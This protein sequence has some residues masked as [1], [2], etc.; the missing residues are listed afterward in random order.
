MKHYLFAAASVVSSFLLANPSGMVVVSGEARIGFQDALTIEVVT[1]RNTVLEWDSFSIDAHETARFVMPDVTSHVLSRVIGGNVS[2]ILGKLEANGELYLINS[3]GVLVGDGAV[4]NTASFIASTFDVLEQRET[5]PI[6]NLGTITASHVELN[7]TEVTHSGKINAFTVE[8]REGRSILVAG[9]AHL[10]GDLVTIGEN[11]EINA[12]GDFGG[13][14][15]LIGGDFQGKNPEIRNAVFV[16]TD[17]TANIHADALVHGDGGKVVLWADN[18]N[19]FYGNITAK[20][21]S[22]SGN[23]G[24]VEVSGLGLLAYHGLASTLAPNGNVGTLLLD[25]PTLTISTAPSTNIHFGGI[26]G[27]NTYCQNQIAM[28]SN[29]N[30]KQLSDQLSH[31]AVTVQS[32]NDIVIKANI[33]GNHPLFI[34]S[35]SNVVIEGGNGS[36][37]KDYVVIQTPQFSI[38]AGQTLTIQGGSADNTFVSIDGK[39]SVVIQA[40]A[41]DILGGTGTGK[42]NFVS[43]LSSQGNFLMT[44][45]N[46]I[47]FQA[48]STTTQNGGVGIG[49]NKAG[50]VTIVS[51]LGSIMISAGSMGS[52]N[53]VLIESGS[54]LSLIAQNGDI[55][56][57]GTSSNNVSVG[58]SGN[59]I[60]ETETLS[61]TGA[62]GTTSSASIVCGAGAIITATTGIELNNTASIVQQSST[63]PILMSTG[64]GL[65]LKNGS[66]VSTTSSGNT[67]LNVDTLSLTNGARIVQGGSGSLFVNVMSD[68][69][70]EGNVTSPTGLDALNQLEVHVM[71]ALTLSS[72][73]GSVFLYSG[74]ELTLT[75]ASLHMNGNTSLNSVGALSVMSSGI[76]RLQGMDISALEATIISMNGPLTIFGSEIAMSNSAQVSIKQ[77]TETLN[78]SCNTATLRIF[79]NA[80]VSHHGTG[81]VVMNSPMGLLLSADT[82]GGASIESGGPFSGNFTG[83]LLIQS[84][85]SNPATI[86]AGQDLVL[87]TTGS[88]TMKTKGNN[89]KG[90]AELISTGGNVDVFLGVNMAMN[91]LSTVQ[92][93]NVLIVIDNNYPTSPAVGPGAFTYSQDA[94]IKGTGYVRI[95]TA[96]PSQNNI[97]KMSVINGIPFPGASANS[98]Y[99]TYYPTV[100]PPPQDGS[101]GFTI[102]YKT[103]PPPAPI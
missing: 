67:T 98:A 57:N 23:G 86:K 39:N 9:T 97:H 72:T 88:L 35:L 54:S 44:A 53:G 80:L 4:I 24:F 76:V 101:V 2:E 95:Y 82:G 85:Q 7:G 34:N 46:D 90:L 8:T 43:L 5:G 70:V 69:T 89:T 41:I 26:C 63:A 42:N 49:N 73:L 66:V 12:S 20:G 75:A 15:I 79:N 14:T 52:V 22:E 62:G 48:S 32:P 19:A 37:S 92:G 81:A 21:G 61:L 74:S 58:A 11:A 31:T 17:E 78:L 51:D 96:S 65:T 28:N 87:S 10:L 84:Q 40:N 93:T 18:T 55:T 103:P 29:L 91:G 1:G 83:D 56:M 36:T 33:I 27:A 102:Y 60:L 3:K 38:T 16:Y 25:P 45:T 94:R 99:N 50:A 68:M 47:T 30:N 64:G 6:I 100:P 71:G 77:G 59:L 13:G